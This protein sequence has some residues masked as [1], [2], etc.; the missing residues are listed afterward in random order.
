MTAQPV[1]PQGR[2]DTARRWTSVLAALGLV[3][4]IAFALAVSGAGV[5]Y[6][7]APVGGDASAAVPPVEP[8]DP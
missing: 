5:A 4:L 8:T 2:P 7:A 3:A 6:A 1:A